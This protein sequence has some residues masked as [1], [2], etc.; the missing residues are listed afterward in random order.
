MEGNF[1]QRV[2]I[3]VYL[4]LVAR[5]RV[6][7]AGSGRSLRVH[8]QDKD[9]PG[10]VSRLLKREQVRYIYPRV[11]FAVRRV[12]MV[13]HI[14]LLVL[15]LRYSGFFLLMLSRSIS[16]DDASFAR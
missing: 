4:Q 15:A 10:R 8:V 7:L 6:E 16:L 14:E 2:A 5:F 12:R 13:G 1:G 9:S 11:R 3:G